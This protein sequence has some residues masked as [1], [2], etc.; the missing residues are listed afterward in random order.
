MP[1][2]RPPSRPHRDFAPPHADVQ[3]RRGGQDWYVR[4]LTGA[5]ATK[6]Y[7]C[8]G[9]HQPIRPATPHVLVWPVLKP[10]LADEAIDARRHWHTPCWRRAVHP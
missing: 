1:R 7:T 6:T 5:A 2:R 3:E 10:L 8:P 9:C 4:R